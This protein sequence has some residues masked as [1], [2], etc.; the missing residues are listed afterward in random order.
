MNASFLIMLRDVIEVA[1]LA[2]IALSLLG[3]GLRLRRMTP[4]RVA[5]R[6]RDRR[7]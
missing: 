1:L 7:A 6:V 5:V 4:A 2:G 3:Y